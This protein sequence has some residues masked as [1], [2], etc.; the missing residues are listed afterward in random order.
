[1]LQ[2]GRINTPFEAL[3][4]WE[5]S[6]PQ[7]A[8]VK[9]SADIKEPKAQGHRSKAQEGEKDKKDIH[10]IGPWV[11]KVTNGLTCSKQKN[12]PQNSNRALE[13]Q[14]EGRV[15]KKK[16]KAIIFATKKRPG[17]PISFRY[18]MVGQSDLRGRGRSRKG[19][20]ETITSRCDQ[21]SSDERA[22]DSRVDV[23]L[24]GRGTRHL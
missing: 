12:G 4:W 23:A 8:G 14:S 13:G 17:S 19:G 18:G 1:V 5:V 21:A 3:Q 6:V 10:Q 22:N 15:V 16:G 2:P 11:Q 24:R 7:Y 20:G 9:V